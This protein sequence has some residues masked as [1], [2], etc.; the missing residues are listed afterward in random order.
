MGRES[1]EEGQLSSPL[2]PKE[3]HEAYAGVSGGGGG[4]QSGPSSAT[5]AVVLTTLVAV[6]GSYVFG[7]A[8]SFLT[9]ELG[10]PFLAWS[11]YVLCSAYSTWSTCV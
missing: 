8:V 1:I 10:V 4:E 3:K 7:S 9:L 5:A 2:L 6:S 11:P